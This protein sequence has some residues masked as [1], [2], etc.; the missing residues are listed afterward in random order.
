MA[1][2]PYGLDSETTSYAR[3]N[4]PITYIDSYRYIGI[5]LLKPPSTR[6]LIW[7]MG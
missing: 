7:K 6:V 3:A 5:Y 1:I 2:R 4:Y